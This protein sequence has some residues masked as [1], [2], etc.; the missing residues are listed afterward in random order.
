M[1]EQFLMF[2]TPPTL[3]RSRPNDLEWGGQVQVTTFVMNGRFE[4][5]MGP[6]VVRE[7]IPSELKN[8]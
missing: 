2:M 4:R 7:T 8:W 3:F 5:D 6:D 1:P